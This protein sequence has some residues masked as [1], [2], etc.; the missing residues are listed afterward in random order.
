MKKAILSIA[1]LLVV[2]QLVSAKT[3]GYFIS[4]IS[5]DFARRAVSDT[6]LDTIYDHEVM[7]KTGTQAPAGASYK[8]LRREA[9]FT[10]C[11]NP[12]VAVPSGST[13]TA[14]V[15]LLVQYKTSATAAI[16]NKTIT[17]AIN[18][19]PT[20]GTAY[21][22][23]DVYVLKDVVWAQVK[24]VNKNILTVPAD[25]NSLQLHYQYS[26]DKVFPPNASEAV[27]V[28]SFLPSTNNGYLKLQ[29]K[30][31]PW[32][33]RYDV[34]WTF[35]DNYS[36]TGSERPASELSYNFRHNSTRVS[37]LNTE[38]EIPLVFEK[39]YVLARVR[40]VGLK[41]TNSDEWEY[42]RWSAFTNNTGTGIPTDGKAV[43]KVTA[44]QIHEADKM[45]WQYRSVFAGD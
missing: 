29:W 5:G 2:V 45:N 20:A 42:G 12:A 8:F 7:L 26:A 37:T 14:S 3:D 21:K 9:T 32:A 31:L 25:D 10:L 11:V 18:Y 4:R 22:A 27:L 39:G 19:N 36:S 44:A 16:Q 34:E 33:E 28:N 40:A 24:T 6:L 38:L 17:L 1:V 30:E 35:V 15:D 13:F 23:K 43:H 41:G